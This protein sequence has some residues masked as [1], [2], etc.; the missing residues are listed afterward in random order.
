MYSFLSNEPLSKGVYKRVINE[1]NDV[2]QDFRGTRTFIFP[3]PEDRMN[4]F[5]FVMYPN[6]GVMAHLP[7]I[8]RMIIPPSYPT[9]PPVL[10]KFTR[11]GRYN[12][13]VYDCNLN[14]MGTTMCLD[15]LRPS[16]ATTS[17]WTK[18]VTLSVLFMAIMQ[19][20]TSFEVLQDG[21]S[22]VKEFVSIEKLKT[23][24]Q[25]VDAALSQ[26]KQI[27]DMSK[28]PPVPVI[29]A[30][31]TECESLI[32][33]ANGIVS[34]NNNAPLIT[35]SQPFKLQGNK[36]YTIGI[37]LS[38]LSSNYVFSIILANN[39]NDMVG[40]KQDTIMF[41]NGVTATA[42]MKLPKLREAKWFYHGKPAYHTKGLVWYITITPDQFTISYKDGDNV[43]I[44][45]DLPVAR[46]TSNHIGNVSNQNFYLNIFLHK[47]TG[48]NN[49]KLPLIKSTTGYNM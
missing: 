39:T 19:T 43:I 5:Y 31:Q 14:T 28:I 30:N 20:L 17:S 48:N 15:I 34:S 29:L 22:Y 25:N 41:R 12:L 7:I 1:M 23:T 44:H 8:G 11:T 46:L 6:D 18:D 10:H 21:G 9:D 13:D 16:G 4:L 3:D 40:K 35:S 38:E 26:W 33:P 42:A 49:I 37:D 2:N 45:G 24:Y 36:S 27:F 47:K 32:F